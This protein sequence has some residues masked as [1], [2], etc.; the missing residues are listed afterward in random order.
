MNDD[1]NRAKKGNDRR[2]GEKVFSIFLMIACVALAVLVLLLAQQNRKLKSQLSTLLEPQMPAGALQEGD[3]LAPLALLDEGGNHL[4]LDF[5]GL[6]ERTLLLFFSPDCPACRETVPVWSALL[7]ENPPRI[8]V[9]GIRLGAGVEDAPNL[10]FTVY[11]P[12]D[13]GQALAGKIPFVPATMI[14]DD[15]GTIEQAWYGM[16]DEE[17]RGEL[18]RILAGSD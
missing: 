14:L 11:T 1:S 12:E 17:K 15:R 16:L 10:P 5:E 18:T 13:A 3:T 7:Q 2:S 4:L 8:R 9:A 6:G